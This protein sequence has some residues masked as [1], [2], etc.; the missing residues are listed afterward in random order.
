VGYRYTYH[1]D[2]I[3]EEPESTSIFSPTKLFIT[4]ALIAGFFLQTTLA[5]NIGLSSNGA[6]E[7]GQGVQQTIFCGG[8]SSVVTMSPMVKPAPTT[9]KLSMSLEYHPNATAWTSLFKLLTVQQVLH[10]H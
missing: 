1:D 10:F 5:A 2:P 4:L 3:V 9:L 7:F 6:T 8:N